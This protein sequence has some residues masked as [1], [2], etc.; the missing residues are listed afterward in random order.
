MPKTVAASIPDHATTV[1]DAS[2]GVPDGAGALELPDDP[3]KTLP[4]ALDDGLDDELDDG[5]EEG[6]ATVNCVGPTVSASNVTVAM[7]LPVDA[8]SVA[9]AIY[10]QVARESAPQP[11][12]L[13]IAPAPEM[14]PS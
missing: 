5:V 1:L 9:G 10:T 8:K 12:L 13:V 4:E 7:P 6:S 14:D 11:Q 3:G 2:L